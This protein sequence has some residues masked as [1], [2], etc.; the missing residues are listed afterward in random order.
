MNRIKGQL[1]TVFP[2]G[3]H[4]TPADDPACTLTATRNL[5]GRLVNNVAAGSVCTT[6]ASSF[7]CGGAN[8]GQFVHI[9][10]ELAYRNSVNYNN[11]ANVI[12]NAF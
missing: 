11:W 4:A 3:T 1:N 7:G 5:F 2:T 10:Q 6:A 8:F 12:T 9:E